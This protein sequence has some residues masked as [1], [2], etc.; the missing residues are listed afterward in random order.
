MDGK[1]REAV[2]IGKKRA[3]E[4]VVG[5]QSARQVT[6]QRLEESLAGC[7]SDTFRDLENEMFEI[8]IRISRGTHSPEV[9]LER[10]TLPNCR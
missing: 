9:R 8:A 4:N 3:N 10:K 5:I 1:R 7:S 2:A 6:Y